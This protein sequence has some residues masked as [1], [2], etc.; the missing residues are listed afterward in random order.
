[1]ASA[2][3]RFSPSYPD[4]R[5]MIC[6]LLTPVTTSMTRSVCSNA[7]SRD[8]PQM[9]RAFGATRP[10]TTSAA[11]SASPI[12]MS[13]PPVTLTSTPVAPEMSTSRSGELIASSMASDARVS[14]TAWDSPM[15][16]IATPPPFM[17]V[18]TSLKSR[19]TSPGFVIVSVSPLIARIRTSSANLNAACRD[20]RGTSS[21]SLSLGIVMTV[22]AD[23]RRRSRPHS[24]ASRR[25]RPSPRNRTGAQPARNA[26]PQQHLLRRT[27]R[28]QVLRVRVR[29]V[30]LRA[31]DALVVDP[32]DR[33][34]PAPADPH[35]LDA[36]AEL[37]Q[38]VLQLRVHPRVLQ[39]R[40]TRQYA[41]PRYH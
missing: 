41:I 7:G 25:S 24:A 33:V 16:I 19:F 40:P 6:L 14:P 36:R 32:G 21:R 37:R 10:W 17:I 1:M 23:S 2:P 28:E 38:H 5:P 20:N 29:R 22:S 27:D 13:V 8:A 11:F 26:A 31:H 39:H 35:D 3:A 9:I 15:P 34:R 30:E 4:L 18:F 12:V